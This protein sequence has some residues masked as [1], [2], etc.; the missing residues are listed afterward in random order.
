MGKKAVVYWTDESIVRL[1]GTSLSCP[2]IAGLIAC[3]WQA[4]PGVTPARLYKSIEESSN[5]YLSPDSLTG[6]GIPDF[7]KALNILAMPEKGI[8]Q[9]GVFPNPFND[10]F[11]VK[12]HSA[13]SQ[14]V[15]FQIYDGVGRLIFQDL[16]LI[17]EAGEN[18]IP[19]NYLS[20]FP[21]GIY[22]IR[23]QSESFSFNILVLK[24]VNQ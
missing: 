7:N 17:S 24:S 22:L 11:T 23:L 20:N 5:H 16:N 14:K 6:Y 18:L 21:R 15:S 9:A 19:V 1:S 2:Q 12:Y 4:R 8:S 13:S 3:L 10:R